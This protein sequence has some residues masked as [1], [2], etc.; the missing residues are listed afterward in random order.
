[1]NLLYKN[2]LKQLLVIAVIG[3]VA[4][5]AS[6]KKGTFD[7]N[8]PN[9]NAP[10]PSTVPS[11][12]TLS[13]GLVQTSSLMFGGSASI[14]DTWMGYWATSGGFTPSPLYVAYQVTNGDFTGNFDAAYLNAA[15]YQLIIN[16][17]KNDPSQINYLAVATIMKAFVFQRIVDLYNNVPY[18]EAFDATKLT[19]KYDDAASI[20][21][22]LVARLDT[23]VGYI[24]SASASAEAVDKKQDVL[25]GGDM[26]K[27]RKFANTLK[28]KILMRLTNSSLSGMIKTELADLHSEDFLGTGEDATVQ[29]GYS[30]AADNQENPYYLDVN[31][32]ASGAAGSNRN[33]WRACTYA[34]N[35]YKEHNDDRRNHFYEVKKYGVFGLVLG[36]LQTASNDSISGVF[37][38]AF[39]ASASQGAYIL[40]AF[41]SYLLQAEATQRG[42]YSGGGTAK[43]LYEQGVKESFRLTKATGVDAYLANNNDALVNWDASTDKIS[44]IVTQAWAACNEV[45]PLESYSNYRR[46]GIPKDLPVSVAPSNT[47]T[48]IP[49]RLMYPQSETS[50]NSGNVPSADINSKIFWMP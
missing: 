44:L 19:P 2:K 16:N 40:P 31:K 30:T 10:S 38:D 22:D 48:H 45:D 27:W 21:K 47:S 39:A 7:I 43:A 13:A 23:A 49:Y 5:A 24:K 18:S 33:Y 50:Y 12:F 26:N 46:T 15:N 20:Y 9:P 42:L 36:S 41:E 29:P 32:T 25:F 11:R 34:V 4:G 37:G 8:T 3:I 6:C 14:I 28:L 35:F 17:S 1:M